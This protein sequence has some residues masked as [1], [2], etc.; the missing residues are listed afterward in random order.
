MIRL[1]YAFL[2]IPIFASTAFAQESPSQG[3]IVAN[4]DDYTIV[5]NA[6]LARDC[7]FGMFTA[8][9]LD[10]SKTACVY[11]DTLRELV[12]RGWAFPHTNH[13]SWGIAAHSTQTVQETCLN[14][15]QILVQGGYYPTRGFDLE[16]KELERT[17]VDGYSAISVTLYNPTDFDSGSA[18]FGN[19]NVFVDC[20]DPDVDNYYDCQD[21]SRYVDVSNW[22]ILECRTI[23]DKHF[24]VDE[25]VEMSKNSGIELYTMNYLDDYSL[26]FVGKTDRID[27]EI[28]FVVTAP[29]GNDVSTWTAFAPVEGE[30]R[31][32]VVVDSSWSQNGIY[33]FTAKQNDIPYYTVYLE[34]QVTHGKIVR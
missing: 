32:S 2:L 33:T 13:G 25:N 23:D 3:G 24:F 30:F 31:T 27:S 19:A 18:R 12:S 34:F 29:D 20:I 9:K 16:L 21:V 17:E 1:L 7:T 10:N 4:V 14:E 5:E 22:P 28:T 11:P 6:S 26:E 8:F 15:N